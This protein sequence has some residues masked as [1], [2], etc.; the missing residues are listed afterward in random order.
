[1][2]FIAA[3]RSLQTIPLN[4]LAANSS[5]Q[6]GKR[7][8]LNLPFVAG[9]EPLSASSL[10]ASFPCGGD[11][12]AARRVLRGDGGG[13]SSGL[14]LC[15]SGLALIGG[16]LPV[17]VEGDVIGGVGVAEATTGSEDRRIAE[18]AVVSLDRGTDP[19]A[20]Y[21]CEV[22]PL[23]IRRPENEGLVMT[24]QW[25][26]SPAAHGPRASARTF[27]FHGSLASVMSSPIPLTTTL[28]PS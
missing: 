8:Q 12:N 21:A 3:A 28:H 15:D 25:L 26:R 13:L 1:V 14:F 5:G 20:G 22:Q 4:R 9:S 17:L 2:W 24:I 7:V 18:N 16:G 11:R 6:G 19:L 23:R 27:W 10:C